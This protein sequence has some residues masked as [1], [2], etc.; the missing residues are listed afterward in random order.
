MG[1]FW[2]VVQNRGTMG[3]QGG[4]L[5]GSSDL[6]SRLSNGP[7]GACYGFLWR[8]PGEANWKAK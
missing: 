3:T 1:P 2:Q 8:L 6:V 5:L 4:L 7:S